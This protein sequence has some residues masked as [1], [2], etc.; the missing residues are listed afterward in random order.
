M[1]IVSNNSAVQKFLE[2]LEGVDREKYL[3]LEAARKE[4]F[5][6]YS[7]V[8]ERIMYGGIMFSLKDDFGG[9]FPSKKHVSFEFSQGFAFQDPDKK[10]EGT[11]KFRRHLKLAS[12]A[13]IENKNLSFFL[14]QLA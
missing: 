11:G 9:L 13:D 2:D 4:V 8:E 5:A 12:I 10:L 7:A 1:S 14:Q 6:Q 3:I